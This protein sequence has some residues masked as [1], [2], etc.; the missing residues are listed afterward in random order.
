MSPKFLTVW[1]KINL[2]NTSSIFNGYELDGRIIGAEFIL[3][4]TVNI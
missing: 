1:V 3:K 2:E 4:I